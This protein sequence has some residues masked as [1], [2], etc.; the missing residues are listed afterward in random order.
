MIVTLQRRS[1][2]LN[3]TL[4]T[5]SEHHRGQE[6]YDVLHDSCG[7]TNEEITAE[8]FDLEDYFTSE[9]SDIGPEMSM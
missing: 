4:D 8:G 5:L 3:K 9:Q 7:L 1:D 6:L 2:I